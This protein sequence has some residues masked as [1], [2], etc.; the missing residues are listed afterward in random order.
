M[1]FIITFF[2]IF[3]WKVNFVLDIS[4]IT[5]LALSLQYLYIHKPFQLLKN[6]IS[7]ISLLILV[8]YSSLIVLV[9][10]ITD[11]TP[12]LRAFRAF[13]M[14]IACFSLYNLYYK[15]YKKPLNTILFHIYLSLLFNAAIIIIMFCNQPFRQF[16]YD[17][18][19]AYKYVNWIDAFLR[20]WKIC[21]LTYGM[22]Q[23]SILQIMGIFL[24]PYIL[25]IT[26]K[27]LYKAFYIISF[28]FIIISSLL[29][30]RSGIFLAIL[31]APLFL[32]F[33]ICNNKQSLTN[34]VTKTKK[35]IMFFL[36]F[37]V[38]YFFTYNYFPT[39]FK[40]I[41]KY[42]FK[43]LIGTIKQDSLITSTIKPMYF[44]PD[45]AITTIFG[46]G[47]YGRT[48]TFYLPSDVGWI[49]SLFAIG[50]IGNLLMLIPY[51]WGIY[52]ALKRRKELDDFAIA[53]ILIFLITILLNFKELSLLTRNQWTI[54]AIIIAI[55]SN[56][57]KLLDRQRE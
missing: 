36:Y 20:G 4:A 21:G 6:N 45:N 29:A 38:V 15:H 25:E 46:K 32:L 1:L 31:L 19:E 10:G 40:T 48:K 8:V 7:L 35:L 13:I 18:T 14:L 24:L 5:A 2:L 44:L 37:L 12:I 28:P 54:Q 52:T 33:K 50:I 42:N 34:I 39:V 57:N 43:E 17:V 49:K 53:V 56:N 16:I 51:I 30:G 3:G 27:K 23:T 26:S 11:L 22:S 55:L 41:T 47:N 9:N